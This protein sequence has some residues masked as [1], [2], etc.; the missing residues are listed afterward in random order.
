M[1]WIPVLVHRASKE[2]ADGGFPVKRSFRMIWS[3]MVK[4]MVN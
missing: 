1:V 2:N 4:L 3:V